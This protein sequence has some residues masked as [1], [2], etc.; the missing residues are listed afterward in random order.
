MSDFTPES[1]RSFARDIINN[2]LFPVLVKEIEQSL[3]D[4]AV[5]LPRENDRG[6]ADLL[7][8]VKALR[9]LVSKLNSESREANAPR[10]APA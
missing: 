9:T 2:P 7:A 5:N 8:E 3:F 6:R 4:Q 1:R 10:Q